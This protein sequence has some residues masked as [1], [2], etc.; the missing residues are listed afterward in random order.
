M[1]RPARLDTVDP[2]QIAHFSKD[3]SLWWDEN[4][5]FA[6]LH[7]LGP[8]RMGYVRARIGEAL[9]LDRESLC[10]F[11]G[12]KILDIGCGGG[13]VSEPLARLGASVTGIDA[14]PGAVACARSHAAEAGLSIEY[15]HTSAE[16]LLAH[17]ASQGAFD[18]VVALEILEHVRDPAAFVACC[19]ALV[20][21]GGVV[22]VSTLNRTA[23]S[24]LLGIVAAEYV[25]GWV[26]KGTHQWR[27]FLRPSEV[28]RMGRACGLRLVDTTGLVFDPPGRVFRLSKTDL[29]VNYFMCFQGPAGKENA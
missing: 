8:V 10:P 6:P 15:E 12:L 4:G 28:A 1:T 7:R 5:P 17:K 11:K 23:K 25:L 3:S 20:R 9:D 18:A 29:D 2:A 13:L 24:F 22:I 19:A 21:P 27:K 16:D 26:P 14:D